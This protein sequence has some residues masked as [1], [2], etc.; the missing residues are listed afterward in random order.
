MGTPEETPVLP[1]GLVRLEEE[2][3]VSALAFFVWG[4]PIERPEETP[5]LPMGLIGPGKES[6]STPFGFFE[7][8]SPYNVDFPFEL[9]AISKF[10]RNKTPIKSFIKKS[11]HKS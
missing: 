10:D 11:E 7:L 5:C 2:T 1:M 6:A 3:D 4:S 9:I 8:G